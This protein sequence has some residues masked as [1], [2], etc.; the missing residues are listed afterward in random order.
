MSADAFPF[1]RSP[2]TVLT[3]NSKSTDATRRQLKTD[4]LNHPNGTTAELSALKIPMYDESILKT[5]FV[6]TTG[7]SFSNTEHV[8]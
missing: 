4:C 7:N 2:E 3:T 6:E 8:N 1:L 5:S